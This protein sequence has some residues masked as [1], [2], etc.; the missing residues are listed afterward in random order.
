MGDGM[1]R[2]P[3]EHRRAGVAMGAG[4]HGLPA[5]GEA[6]TRIVENLLALVREAPADGLAATPA[7][8]VTRALL[9]VDPTRWHRLAAGLSAPRG[10]VAALLDLVPAVARGLG[11]MWLEDRVSF[12]EVTMGCAALQSLLRDVAP[13]PPAPFDAP[14]VAVLLR[15]GETHTLGATMAAACLRREGASVMLL[16]GRPDAELIEAVRG[17]DLTSV[18]LSASRREDPSD[19]A[20]LVAGLRAASGAPVLLGGSILEDADPVELRRATGADRVTTDPRD[21]LRP[22]AGLAAAP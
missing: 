22:V 1:G 7:T 13:E 21:A 19:L 3:S 11:R 2:S 18:C 14:L 6:P 17:G 8:D 15:A 4:L 5:S 10:D 16:M 20:P 12:A 9:D